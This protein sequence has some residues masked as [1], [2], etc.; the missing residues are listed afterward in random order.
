MYGIQLFKYGV[1]DTRNAAHEYWVTM[2]Y[3]GDN[4][5]PPIAGFT[6]MTQQAKNTLFVVTH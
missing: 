6:P 5:T 4:T 2:R 3:V 1:P